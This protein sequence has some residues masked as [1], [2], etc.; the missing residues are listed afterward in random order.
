MIQ[1]RH[2]PNVITL[3]RLALCIPLIITFHYQ[4]YQATFVIYVIQAILDFT[5]GNTARLFGWS[6]RFGDSL[7]TYV[8]STTDFTAFACLLSISLI[9]LWFFLVFLYRE[10]AIAFLR[11]LGERQNVTISGEWQGKVKAMFYVIAIG[12]SF[13]NI[14]F[15]HISRAVNTLPWLYIAAASC[16][17]SGTLYLWRYRGIIAKAWSNE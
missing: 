5:D 2:V 8:D 6:S 9:P 10:I 3:T 14:S 1:A 17:S 11:Y 13:W 7:D 16:I 12:L 15:G 4:A